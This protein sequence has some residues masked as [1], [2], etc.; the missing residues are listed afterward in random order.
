MV[1]GGGGMLP[2]GGTGGAGGHTGV[3]VHLH[4]PPINMDTERVVQQVTRGIVESV[5]RGGISELSLG[6][7]SLTP[8]TL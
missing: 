7:R 1:G 6:I 8:A 3:T 5:R 4:N 2:G